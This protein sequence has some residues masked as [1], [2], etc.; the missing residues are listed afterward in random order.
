MASFQILSFILTFISMISCDVIPLVRT[1][2]PCLALVLTF[3]LDDVSGFI[4]S[5]ERLAAFNCHLWNLAIL[6]LWKFFFFLLFMTSDFKKKKSVCVKSSNYD[7]VPLCFKT[8]SEWSAR[9]SRSWHLIIHLGMTS[10]VKLSLGGCARRGKTTERLYLSAAQ[11]SKRNS[12]NTSEWG[13][14]KTR[15]FV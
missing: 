14:C 9:L 7:Y 2:R 6:L 4:S 1:H 10:R 8:D 15:G 3:H 5:D 12:C 13:R 11:R